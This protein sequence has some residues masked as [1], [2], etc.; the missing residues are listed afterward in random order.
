MSAECMEE[1]IE[2]KLEQKISEEFQV[3]QDTFVM[4]VV[5]SL[6]KVLADR[7]P[8]GEG[9]RS[10]L[11]ALRG[12]TVSLQ[13]AYFWSGNR[14]RRAFVHV[15]APEG[16]KVRVRTVHLVPCSY[17]CHSETDEGYFTTKPG[18]YPDL[19]KDLDQHGIPVVVGQWRSL[20]VDFE[21]AEDAAAEK[22]D[23]KVTLTWKD[24]PD[25]ILAET[26]LSVDVIGA[27]KPEHTLPHTEWFHCDCLAN[28]YNVEVFSEEHWR[29][30]ENFV[31]HAVKRNITMILTP[32][33]TPPL[34]TAVGG[35]RRTV[36]LID[37]EVNNGSY[38]FGFDKLIR[39]VKMCQRCG[40][41][42]LE[43]SH[44]FSQW[45]AVSTPK[46][47]AK[48]DGKEVKLF[49][50]HTK[51]TSPEYTEFLQ[52]LL[53]QL[54]DVLKELGV[55]KQCYFHISDEPHLD[56]M[57]SYGAARNIVKD[58][59]KGYHMIDALSDYSFYQ[60]GLID[61]PVCSN[62]HIET[63]LEKRPE[64]L[65]TYYCTAQYL[66]VSNRFIAERGARTRI[67]GTQ[68]YK[69]QISG[70]LQ[71]GYNFYNSEYS[72]YPLNPYEITDA[73]GTFPSGDSFLV[74]PGKDGE[75]L[76]SMRMMYME[77][78]FDDY[79]A[80]KLLEQLTDR[81]TVMT[82][83]EEDKVGE[84][85]FSQYPLTAQYMEDVRERINLEIR[86]AIG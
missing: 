77:K 40:V 54:L 46:V 45:G 47:M 2:K 52:T 81:E 44:F 72:L 84:I 39:W 64:L 6:E 68:L 85:T 67:L 36:Q 22:L 23:T 20:W 4:K 25:T 14:K 41:K 55:D 3:P 65:W 16:V 43:I 5:S 74:Y 76:D 53:P 75:A 13:L 66:G 86:K 21:V 71:W 58:Y 29:I 59:L 83:L 30:V 33:F 8:S 10:C 42:Y 9:S 50:W 38:T 18:M 69:Y 73:D 17:P 37:I 78:V 35:E 49:G 1:V 70:F 26:V 11:T 31:R 48:V 63:F 15:E 7:T 62:D 56:Q 51:A 82:C 12:E 19:L 61:E 60:S 80:M 28:Y 34:D 24:E 27:R 57:E 79:N 32:I